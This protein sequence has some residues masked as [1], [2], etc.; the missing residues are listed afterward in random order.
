[1]DLEVLKQHLY[2]LGGYK[3]AACSYLDA[4]ILALWFIL[5]A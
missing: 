2:V 3:L 1:M 5:D 4:Y